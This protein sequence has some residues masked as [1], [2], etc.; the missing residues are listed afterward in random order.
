[1]VLAALLSALGW[2]GADASE[3]HTRFHDFKACR[4]DGIR[5]HVCNCT[6]ASVKQRAEA[7]K[8]EPQLSR[9]VHKTAHTSGSAAAKTKACI[10]SCSN[11][12]PRRRREDECHQN[13]GA[14]TVADS[15]AAV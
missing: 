10:T 13:A 15:T 4:E 7:G 6:L 8:G 11:S 1:M 14:P 3:T 12:S 5:T 2:V 9:Y